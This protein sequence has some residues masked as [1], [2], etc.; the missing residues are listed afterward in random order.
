MGNELVNETVMENL[1]LQ[2]NLMGM[3]KKSCDVI[4]E[5]YQS[6]EEYIVELLSELEMKSK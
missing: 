4:V 3:I 6:M 2:G 1:K 5:A